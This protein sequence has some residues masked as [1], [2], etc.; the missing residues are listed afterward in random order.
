MEQLNK[1]LIC[2]IYLE[3]FEVYKTYTHFD[4]LADNS[5]VKANASIDWTIKET[6]AAITTFDYDHLNDASHLD[7]YDRIG[8]LLTKVT[9]SLS[10]KKEVFKK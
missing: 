2:Q 5:K 7:L 9:S 10:A 6:G 8:S 4:H 1:S 3:N